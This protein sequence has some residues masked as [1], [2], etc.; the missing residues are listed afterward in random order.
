M[1]YCRRICIVTG[2]R[3][4]YG[5]LRGLMDAAHCDPTV[6]LQVIATGMHL[7]QQF[8][9]TY[10]QIEEDGFNIDIKVDMRLTGDSASAVTRAMG[11]GLLGFADALN[12][13]RPDVLVLL[14][15]RFEALV[16]A[17]AA[18]VARVPIAHIHGGETSEGAV[19]EAFRHA[20]TKMSHL[21]FVAAGSYRRRV[22]QLGE[23]PDRVFNVGAPGLDFLADMQWLSREE[24]EADLG[25]ALAAPLILATYHPATLGHLPPMTAMGEVLAALDQFPHANVV[26]TYPNADTGGRSLIEAIERYVRANPHRATAFVSLGRQRYLSLLRLADVVLGNSSS[27]LTEAP[28]LKTATVNVGDRQKGR[29]KAGSVIDAG[30]D[31]QAI[32]AALAHALSPE[33]RQIV[34]ITESLYG[35]GR[36]S[37]QI[38]ERL[39]APLPPMQKTFFDIAH[40]Y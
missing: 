20:I 39:K 25:F 34:S 12:C 17:Q 33:F 40:D 5:L 11:L 3:A 14:G 32:A 28:A 18:L 26:I 35:I 4:D 19:D 21:H 8:G 13:L 10:R 9:A 24:L 37:A 2:T 31:R 1:S 36:A 38:L 22:I 6:Q 15:D 16:A 29:L 23:S 7:S 27:G 30:E